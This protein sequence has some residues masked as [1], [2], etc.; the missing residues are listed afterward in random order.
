MRTT[1]KVSDLGLAAALVSRSVEISN[2]VKDEKG[3]M[4]FIFCFDDDLE[5]DIDTAIDNYWNNYLDVD[6][7]RYF[8]N[9]KM[10]KSRIY[11]EQ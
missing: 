11:S 4:S 8:E 3:R 6:A 10:L 1:V 5:A 2:T 7:R 9:I